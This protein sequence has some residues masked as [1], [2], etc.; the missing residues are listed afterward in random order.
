MTV[1]VGANVRVEV[2]S[3]LETALT[4]SAVTLAS[5]GVATSTAH[6]LANGDIVVF[7]VS[8]GMVELDGQAVRVANVA[9][10]TFE[11]ESLDTGDY[12]VWTS[13]TC[14][15]VSAFETM[16]NAQTVSMPNPDPAKLD[17][18]TLLDKAKQF[19][20]GLPE[21]P[22][23]SFEGIYDP[24]NAAEIEIK[25]ATKANETR[26]FRITWA[27]GQKEVFNANVSGGTGFDLPQNDIAKST[28]SFT[29][30]KDKISYAT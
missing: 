21:A 22:D 20:F 13:G 11:L 30:V 8:G 24:F 5:P 7:S 26:V 23:G 28:I 3:T 1:F 15:E 2:Q 29:P 10:D 14:Q 27:G 19:V 4:V 25:T 9:T 17:S 6:G 12:S 18:T 16:A